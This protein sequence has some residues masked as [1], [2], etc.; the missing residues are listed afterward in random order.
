MSC[1]TGTEFLRV[2][3][4]QREER[5]EKWWGDQERT[6]GDQAHTKGQYVED[7]LVEDLI[8]WKLKIKYSFLFLASQN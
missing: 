5:E 7:N 6:A 8:L 3:M 1:K 4:G 2:I